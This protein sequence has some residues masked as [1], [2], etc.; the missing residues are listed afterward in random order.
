MIL[1]KNLVKKLKFGSTYMPKRA[2]HGNIKRHG[3][4]V[5]TSKFLRRMYEQLLKVSAHS[6]NLL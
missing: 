4:T 5:D 6:V 2:C 3:Q 1:R